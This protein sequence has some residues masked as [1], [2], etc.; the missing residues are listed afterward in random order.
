MDWTQIIRSAQ[1]YLEHGGMVIPPLLLVMFVLWYALGYRWVTIRRGD[2][3]SVRVLIERQR[4]GKRRPPRGIVD[5]AVEKAVQVAGTPRPD[6]RRHLD[7][8]LAGYEQKVKKYDRLVGTLVVVAPL[9]GLLGT[10]SGMIE[11]FTSLGEGAFHSR[12]GGIS[13]GISEALYT[14]QFGLTVAIPGI[15][16]GRILR[17]RQ[18]AILGELAKIKDLVILA[19]GS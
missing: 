7:E 6:I 12:S 4:S 8:A 16:I 3:R 5:A 2:R 18:Q 15:I 13:G 10:V 17:R 19:S 14:T 11:T 9:L 1:Q